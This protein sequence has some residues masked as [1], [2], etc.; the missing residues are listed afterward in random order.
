MENI[1]LIKNIASIAAPLTKAVVDVWLAP[2][3]KSL[4]NHWARNRDLQDHFFNDKFTEYLNE[5]YKTYSV[6]NILAF[7]NQQRLLNDIYIPLRLQLG[8][9]A[10]EDPKKFKIEDYSDD[11]IPTYKKVLITDTAGMGKSTL[12]RKLFLSIIENNKGVPIFIELRRLSKERTIIKEIFNEF[13]MLNNEV[14]ENFIQDLIK[15]GDFI[16]FLD[17]YDEVSSAEKTI[18]THDIQEFINNASNNYFILTSRP[19]ISLSSFGQF[20]EFSIIPL[21]KSESYDLLIKYDRGGDLS[22]SL[23]KR[24]EDGL[25]HSIEEFLTNPLL[26]SLLYTAYEYKHTV[27]LKKHVF[28]RQVFDA[29]FEAHDL[30]KGDFYQREKQCKLSIDDFHTAVRYIAFICLKKDK[31]EFTKDEIL[32]ILHIANTHCEILN[33]KESDLLKDLITSVPLFVK[34]GLYYKWAH[35]SIFEYFVAQFIYLDSDEKKENLLGSLSKSGFKY[36]NI[37]DIYSNVDYKSF[38]NV[39]VKEIVEKFMDY[40]HSTFKE[41]PVDDNLV[42]ERQE[43]VYSQN[44]IIIQISND[45]IRTND[46]EERYEEEH[47]ECFRILEKEIKD[48]DYGMRIGKGIEEVYS[49]LN[50][51]YIFESDDYESINNMIY[52]IL[53]RAKDPLVRII[54]RVSDFDLTGFNIEKNS[55]HRLSDSKSSELNIKRNFRHTNALISAF[56]NTDAVFDYSKCK[57]FIESLADNTKIENHEKFLSL[58]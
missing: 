31:I 10:N 40:C 24:L 20:Q 47:S 30:S 50:H 28:Y 21:E 54:K 33:F 22:T 6:I 5:K 15:R 34:D 7:R 56:Y 12:S 17:G 8:K 42:R 23:I 38:R 2:K 41:L 43:L 26:V 35:K 49:K 29:L 45:S 16:F 51:S 39:I 57:T 46:P 52:Y 48:H 55:I 13:K 3:L 9:V 1:E 4:E 44:Y 37:I 36:H 19:D 14:N 11:L 27:P 58:E 18:I 25:Y 53:K 32:D